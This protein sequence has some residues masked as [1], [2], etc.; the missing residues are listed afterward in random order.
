MLVPLIWQDKYLKVDQS[1][2]TITDRLSETGSHVET[3]SFYTSEMENIVVG[4]V[5]SLEKHP[6]ADKLSVLKIDTGEDEDRTI[7]TAATNVNEGDYLFVIKSGAVLDNGTKIED[8]DFFGITSQGMLLAYSEMDYPDSVIPKDLKDGVIILS[9]EFKPGTLASEVLSS[10]TPVIEYEITPNRPDCLSILGMAR[11]TAASFG[12]KVS[13]PSTDYEALDE[14]LYDYTN[15]V[16]VKSDACKRFTARVIKDVTVEE[17]P[18]WLQNY[19]ILAGMR[20]INNIV[21]IT[22]F[23]MLETGQPIHAYDLEKL[24]DKKIIVRNAQK[25]EK[26]TTLDGEERELDE[27]MLVIADSKEAIGLAGLMGSLDSEVTKSTKT[28]LLESANFSSDSVRRTSKVLGLRTEASTRFEKGI[29]V[30]NADFAS[31]RVMAMI[32]E[33]GAGKVIKGSIDLGQKE[34]PEN[35]VD[36]RI[37]RLNLL[38]GR[39]FTK[40]EAIKSLEL[41]EFEVEDIDED[42]IRAKVPSHRMDIEIEADLIE[43]VVRLYGMGRV[44]SKPLVSTLK[45]GKR[46]S[47]RLLKDDLKLNLLGQLFSEATTYSFISPKEYDRLGFPADSSYRNYVKIINPLGEDYS[48]MRT[49]LMANMLEQISKNI[50]HKQ[51]DIKFFE[52]GTIFKK[53]EDLLPI[54]NQALCMGLYGD[55]SFYDLKDFFLKA[56]KKTG[57]VG[58]DFKA[59]PDFYALHE[60][61]CADIYLEGEK[62]GIMGQVSYYAMDEYDIDKEA[63]ILELNLSQIL[64]K[65]IDQV[66][67]KPIGKFPAIERDYAFVCDRDLESALIE[68]TIEDH[69]QGLVKKIEL[70]DIYTG[71]QI[72]KDKKSIAYKIFYRSDEKTLKEKDIV[73][74]EENILKALD[75]LGL[76]VR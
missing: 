6:G 57:F 64:D 33:L 14:D 58:F 76:S 10:N 35:F 17:S 59:N 41:L 1:L 66:K 65:R 28:I 23:V 13:Y 67:Y 37:S 71:N 75:D 18:Q 16:E 63:F 73:K 72:A 19:L 3:V 21:D 56:M 43:E 12:K 5:K 38:I 4:Y 31:K 36:L 70:F 55:Y 60:G 26:I 44:E 39:E 24:H 53:S 62:V 52:I 7:I 9:G 48:V 27:E 34:T 51:D 47:M 15:G 61:R 8:H 50:K 25:G 20:P 74:L 49:T 32:N 2:K 54:E 29:H 40:E 46:D 69:G 45:R 42:T 30:E 22:N 68:K 11:E